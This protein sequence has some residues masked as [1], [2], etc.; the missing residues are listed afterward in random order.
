MPDTKKSLRV[1]RA[2]LQLTQEEF[3]KLLNMPVSTYRKK[4]S[5]ES[6]F[7]L[8]E[9]YQISKIANKTVEDIFF[10]S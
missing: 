4:E 2:E 5:G 8:D 9:V 3:A 10:A 6:K 7:T 1:L